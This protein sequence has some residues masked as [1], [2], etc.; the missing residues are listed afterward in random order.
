MQPYLRTEQCPRLFPSGMPMPCRSLQISASFPSSQRKHILHR[1]GL[2]LVEIMIALTIT[3]IV[4][5]AMAQAFQY[6]SNEI[7]DGRSVL[8]MSSRLRSAQ[9]LMRLDLASRTVQ[10]VRAYTDRTPPGYFEY[11]EGPRTD[12]TD[13]KSSDSGGLNA[14]GAY[15][16]DFDDVVA[17]TCRKV[18]GSYRGRFNSELPA[19]PLILTRIAI[20]SQLA[21]VLWFTGVNDANGDSVADFDETITL[22]RRVLLIRPDL[23]NAI[24]GAGRNGLLSTGEDGGVG[25]S[26]QIR[27]QEFFL[28][29]DISARWI[30]SNNNGLRDLIVANTLEDL[31]QRQNRF[32]HS[33]AYPHELVRAEFGTVLM[34]TDDDLGD[35]IFAPEYSG[36]DILLTDLAA[37]DFRIFSPDAGAD[38][39]DIDGNDVFETLIST[40][41]AAYTGFNNQDNVETVPLGGFIDLGSNPDNFGVTTFGRSVPQFT[42][43]PISTD[44][45]GFTKPTYCTWT[46]RYESDDVNQDGDDLVDEGTNGIDDDNANG[47]DDPGEFETAPPYPFRVRGVQVVFRIIEKDSRQ[48]RQA[49]VVQNFGQ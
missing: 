39:L 38:L 19:A 3:M 9:Q 18:D 48:L 15:L 6:A 5:F 17:M 13:L 34:G 14:Q 47:V 25:S 21:E 10:D 45:P 49:T 41:D 8:E 28:N 2:T 43:D 22:Y 11:V 26:Q 30:D 7:A 24:A 31:A 44:S 20:E 42:S 36:D 32:G 4:L 27:A 29:N 1:A 23:N 40:T 16:G 12:G 37:F 33:D 35:G 46:P